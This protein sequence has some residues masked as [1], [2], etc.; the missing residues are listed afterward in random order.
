MTY[1]LSASSL[2][3]I[4][5]VTML[6][7]HVGLLFFPGDPLWRLVGRISFPLFAFLI[8]EGYRHSRDREAYAFRLGLLA[9]ISQMPF[10]LML[11]AAGI[12]PATL[13]IFF[14]LL[15]G[16]ISIALV[17]RLTAA[18]AVPGV[19]A[20]VGAAELLRFDYG[21]YGVL[22]ILASALFLRRRNLG[23]VVLAT[24]SIVRALSFGLASLSMQLF[25]PFALPFLFAYNGS[26]GR[27]LP[28]AL[29]YW[30]YPVHM[31]LLWLIWAFI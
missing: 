21:A 10:M 25:A 26:K 29:F 23:A 16:L 20:L 18:Q 30:F 3:I 15:A 2:K 8:A 13:N 7:D 11:D 6:I 5:A 4:A 22:M 19:L 9:L 1:R 28:R 14:T 17:D 31:L 27:A 12:E 24:L